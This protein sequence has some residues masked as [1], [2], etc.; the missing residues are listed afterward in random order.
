MYSKKILH[1]DLSGFPIFSCGDGKGL[2]E[3]NEIR[4]KVDGRI[5]NKFLSRFP[6]DLGTAEQVPSIVLLLSAV[7]LTSGGRGPKEKGGVAGQEAWSRVIRPSPPS[8]Y[9]G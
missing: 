4:Q 7:R 5:A 9:R 1:A 6:R 2:K 8:L 3:G